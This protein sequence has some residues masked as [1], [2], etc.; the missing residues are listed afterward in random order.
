MPSFTTYNASGVKTLSPA[1]TADAAVELEARAVKLADHLVSTSN[2][3]AV[4]KAQVGLGNVTNAAQLVAAN[5][6]SDLPS[7]STARTN[8]GLGTA[9]TSASTAFATASHTHPQSDVTG[10]TAALAAKADASTTVTLAGTQTVTNKTLSG[11]D[12]TITNLSATN[13]TTGTLDAARLPTGIDASKIGGGTVSNTEFG[14]LDGV[15]SGIQGQINALASGGSYLPLG[16][17]TLTGALSGTTGTFSG[18][19]LANGITAGGPA[20]TGIANVLYNDSTVAQYAAC[21]LRDKGSPRYRADFAVGYFGAGFN[22]YDDT[23][24]VYM[25]FSIDGSKLI[26]NGISEGFVGIGTGSP[27]T[28]LD[29]NGVATL[30]NVRTRQTKID[31]AA[32]YDERALL[33]NAFSVQTSNTVEPL[34]SSTLTGSNTGWIEATITATNLT[35]NTHAYSVSRWFVVWTGSGDAGTQVVQSYTYDPASWGLA[36]A[37]TT[38]GGTFQVNFT[39]PGNYNVNLSAKIEHKFDFPTSGPSGGGY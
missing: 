26:L 29:V 27:S 2:P 9:A 5:N 33:V 14:Y 22:A 16:G 12:N 38:S 24:N 19:M 36:L 6:L 18:K 21:R 34:Y 7:A 23:A 11:T 31:A 35:S 25:P 1:P 15:T 8:L 28:L 4:T 32:V 13:V 30:A 37:L 39:Q 3:H 17:G 10:L 20:I